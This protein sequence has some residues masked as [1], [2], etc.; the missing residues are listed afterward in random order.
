LGDNM[1]LE[2]MSVTLILLGS[3]LQWLIAKMSTEHGVW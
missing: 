3:P 2:G 1:T